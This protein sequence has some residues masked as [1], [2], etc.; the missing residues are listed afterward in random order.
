MAIRK[1][2]IAL[3]LATTMFASYGAT[4]AYAY[5]EVTT[6]STLTGDTAGNLDYKNWKE[7]EWTGKASINSGSI[8]IS[9]G[10]SEKDLNFAWYSE[11]KGTPAIKLSKSSD[12]KDG[13]IYK[14][15][16]IEI[17]RGNGVNTYLA[18][19]K[20]DANNALEE[21]TTY[22]YSYTDNINGSNPNWSTP[23]KYQ[24]HSF[25]KY[26]MI[27]VGDPQI[28]ASGSSGENT[29]DDID[30]AINTYNWNKTLNQTK[31]TAPNASFILSAGDQIDYAGADKNEVREREYAGFLYPEL[32]RSMPIATS[33]G[34]HESKGNDYKYHYN[35]PNDEDDLGSTESGSDYYFNYGNALF[36][37]LNSNNRNV[38]EH[39]ELMK[40][41]IESNKDAKWKFV[42]FHHDIYGS[43]QP[44]SDTDGA[45]LRIL[46]APLMDKYDIDVCLTG[47]DH[48]YARTFQVLDGKVVDY[49]ASSNISNPEGTLY[50]AAGSATGSKFYNLATTKQY[51]IAERSNAQLPTFSTI[52]LTDNSFTI[53]TY[54]YNGKKY[55]DDF[56]I[57]KDVNQESILDLMKSAEDI[58]KT[59]YTKNSIERLEN[60]L[61][62]ANTLLETSKDGVPEELSKNYDEK[63]QGDN[64]NDPL[65]YYGYAQG[66]YKSEESTKLKDGYSAFLDKTMDNAS[67][68]VKDMD[69]SNVYLSLSSS[70]DNLVLVDDENKLSET[71]KN[72]KDILDKAVEGNKV[73]NYKVGSKDILAQAIKEAE[74]VLGDKEVVGDKILDTNSKLLKA[75]ERFE[76]SKVVNE[77]VKDD[78]APSSN[79]NNP[80]NSG[81]IVKTGDASGIFGTVAIAITSLVGLGGVA[82][83]KKRKNK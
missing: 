36:I 67:V 79:S 62:T 55:A 75:L 71:V 22:Y 11:K 78:K 53:K 2:V 64:P 59:I 46:F 65:N 15:Q 52:D 77:V 31:I 50:L 8:A 61:N 4:M 30:I 73:G 18:S 5:G 17:N 14:G 21:N 70:M 42:M 47:H 82:I 45:N 20:V 37:V 48:S 41:A 3:S 80:S 54:D 58:D 74:S 32:L 63:N 43:G 34:N 69:L 56:T 1:K 12:M 13:K 7:K 44:H 23:E 16:A 68:A 9:P 72:A 66:D 25:S 29:I 38:S 57:T 19:N 49:G 28:G 26:Q 24:T 27:Y 83:N 39:D 10:R 51:Y 76:A 81:N 60:A 6:P 33:I 40:K 35:T